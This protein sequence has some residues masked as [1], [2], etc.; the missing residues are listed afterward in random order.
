MAVNSNEQALLLKLSE[1]DERAF[2]SLFQFYREGVYVGA[3]NLVKTHEQAQEILQEV[4]IK[5]WVNRGTINTVDNFKAYLF[6]MTRNTVFDYFRKVASDAKKTEQF[7]LQAMTSQPATVEQSI[8]YKELEAHLD[9]VLLKMPEKC[10]QVFVLC[11]LEGRSY[12][13]VSDMLNISPAT[14]NNHIVKASRILK[15]NWQPEYFSIL[16]FLH[17]A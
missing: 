10:R 8:A 13:E 1:G 14:I 17:F 16:L 7:L 3:F 15:A 5:V 2:N 12:K 4:F 9:M 11:R 6:S